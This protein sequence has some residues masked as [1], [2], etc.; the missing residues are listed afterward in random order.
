MPATSRNEQALRIL[1]SGM[2][3]S[4]DIPNELSEAIRFLVKLHTRRNA[5]GGME[6]REQL[7]EGDANAATRA[8]IHEAWAILGAAADAMDGK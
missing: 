2:S 6:V 1:S 7:Q 8:R 4:A 5:E 3:K